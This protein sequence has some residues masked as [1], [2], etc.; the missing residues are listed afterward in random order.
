MRRQIALDKRNEAA[1]LAASVFR[2]LPFF[3]QSEHI[4]C[5]LPHQDEFDSHP[6]IELIW[7][8]NKKCYL[9]ILVND[10]ERE[11]GFVCY[12]K[13]DELHR[14]RYSIL[15]PK[16]T[17]EL[18]MPEKLDIVLAPLI[19]FD[20]RG[21]RLGTG[22]GYY[23]HTFA[24]LKTQYHKHPRMIGLAYAIQEVDSLPHDPWDVSMQGVVTELGYVDCA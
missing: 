6:L 18:W 9:P 1:K 15:E 2:E 23:D 8:Q 5:Y 17:S 22:G 11:L 10:K 24:F 14:N 12:E 4:A 16:N 21:H 13:N 3:L 19:A 7:S 20:K